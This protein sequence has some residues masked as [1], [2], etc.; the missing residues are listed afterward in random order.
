[1]HSLSAIEDRCQPQLVGDQS[2]SVGTALQMV[3][4]LVHRIARTPVGGARL[5]RH[6][7]VIYG[8]F[9]G[10]CHAT[11]LLDTLRLTGVRDYVGMLV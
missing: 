7:C 2:D 6:L 10:V 9:C 3:E 11:R 4:L 8:S 5:L 1:M